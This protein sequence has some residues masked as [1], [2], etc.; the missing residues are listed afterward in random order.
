MRILIT[1]V[2]MCLALAF[3]AAAGNYPVGTFGGINDNGNETIG[4]SLHVTGPLSAPVLATGGTTARQLSDWAA[5]V[6]N[7]A[8]FG[9]A[10]N[11][12]TNDSAAFQAA[13][14]AAPNNGV[15]FVP[16]GG[17]D[18]SPGPTGSGAVLWQLSGN[19]Y[20]TGT[21]PVNGIGTDT[22][23]TV[24]GGGKFI[25]RYHSIPDGPPVLRADALIDHA[26]GTSGD[27]M[28]A[29]KVNTTVSPAGAALNNYVWG[30]QSI[31]TSSS[32]GPSQ[33]VAV[34]ATTFRPANAL[35]DGLGPRGEVWALYSEVNDQTGAASNLSGSMVGYENDLYANG[36]DPS[37]HRIVH[38]MEI[39]Q[40]I[41]YSSGGAALRVGYGSVLGA[42]DAYSTVGIGYS[43]QAPFDTAGFDASSATS[44]SNAPAFRMAANQRFDM[45]GDGS[46]ELLYS[47]TGVLQWL[48][49]GIV[50]FSVNNN[51]QV[52][53]GGGM[54]VTGTP[55]V[56]FDTST[57]NLGGPAYRMASG[58][59]IALEA[60]GA[61]TLSYTSSALSYKV[62][63][64]TV[65]SVS[66]TGVLTTAGTIINGHVTMQ[67]A[68]APTVSACGTSPSLSATASDT[69]GTITEGAMATGCTLTFGSAFTTAPDCVI[70]S[71]N[72]AP[73]T[74]YTT[75]TAALTITNASASGNKYT[76]HCIQ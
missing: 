45:A 29:M 19:A 7:V 37:S 63:G 3:S 74:G 11:G 21:T 50:N 15:I 31:L 25:S 2:S 71:A 73:F 47:S 26:G 41:P 14:T 43:L 34:D 48:V 36:G 1:A 13:R 54:I 59:T 55:A 10:M 20:G 46:H 16:A 60:T 64:T 61:R 69:K 62:N 70:S 4:G 5:D 57:A 30:L 12:T 33:N 67:G 17:F 52:N 9:A 23:E 28:S 22:V 39:G 68:I 66:D 27:V 56:G 24:L 18:V 49:S 40:S 65:A 72:G 35:A 32:L 44:V 58:Q 51:G 76:Y 42:N 53:A 75:N 8:A 6:T 38:Q